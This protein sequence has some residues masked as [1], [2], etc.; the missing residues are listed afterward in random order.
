MRRTEIIEAVMQRMQLITNSNGYNSNAGENVYD[1][2]GRPLL[3]QELPSIIV[4]DP[5][6]KV[7]NDTSSVSKNEI[8]I[9]VVV[10]VSEGT[11]TVRAIRELTEYVIEVFGK[12]DEKL[13]P[14]GYREIQNVTTKI[15]EE[16]GLV[17]ESLIEFTVK[18]NTKKF[19]I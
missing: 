1:W 15:E 9:K 6:V 13:K 3:K 16:G 2:I 17:A 5:T 19:R 10:T 18:Y 8:E 4:F 12:D 14:L 11:S 7:T